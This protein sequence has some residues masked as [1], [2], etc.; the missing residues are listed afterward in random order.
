MDELK[1]GIVPDQHAVGVTRTLRRAGRAG[2]VDDQ[3][4]VLGQRVHGLELGPAGIDK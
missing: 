3:G 1:A 4:I 2:R